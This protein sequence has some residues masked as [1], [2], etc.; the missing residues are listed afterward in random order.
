M[1]VIQGSNH[2]ERMLMNRL[3]ERYCCAFL[4]ERIELESILIVILKHSWEGNHYTFSVEEIE[5]NW[6][7]S[8]VDTDMSLQW[9]FRYEKLLSHPKLH[10]Y[11]L[12]RAP[13]SICLPK[14]MKLYY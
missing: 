4:H 2:L 1:D 10:L 13:I 14:S 9:D 11:S 7:C 5:P 3:T 8:L 6:A 12:Q